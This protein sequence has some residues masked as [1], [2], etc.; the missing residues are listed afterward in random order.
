MTIIKYNSAKDITIQFDNG[1]IKNTRYHRFKEGAVPSVYDKT[2]YNIGY[3]GEGV[4]EAYINDSFTKSY[5]KWKSMLQRCYDD[6]LH[7]KRPRYKDCAVCEEWHNYQNFAKWFEDNYYEIPGE[8]MCLD[9]DILIK[10]NKMYSPDTCVF[11]PNN[12]NIL[13]EK[14]NSIRGDLPIG[15]SF[16]KRD[17]NFESSLKINGR[18]KFLGYYPTIEQAFNVYKLKKEDYIKQMADKYKEYLPNNLYESM[19]NYEVEVID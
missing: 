1:F 18:K 13:F 3:L 15:V 9:K 11:V 12:I 16:N 6:K 7:V 8:T 4:Y 2:V 10:G 19:Y 14:S 17:N 5:T